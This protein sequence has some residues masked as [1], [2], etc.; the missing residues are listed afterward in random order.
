LAFFVGAVMV[1]QS[2]QAS[3]STCPQFCPELVVKPEGSATT[4]ELAALPEV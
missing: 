3:G 1:S 4:V 2:Q